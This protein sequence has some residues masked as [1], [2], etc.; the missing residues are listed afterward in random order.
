MKE[1]SS[2]YLVCNGYCSRYLRIL[3]GLGLVVLED[4]NRTDVSLYVFNV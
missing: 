1:V 3:T 2:I 4:Q